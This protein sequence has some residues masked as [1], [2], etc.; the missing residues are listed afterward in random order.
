MG[1]VDILRVDF[2]FGCV[3][4]VGL[5]G[6]LQGDCRTKFQFSSHMNGS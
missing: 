5:E 1:K 2:M 6:W 3:I 4:N